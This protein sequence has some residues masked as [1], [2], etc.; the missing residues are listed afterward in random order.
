LLG[1]EETYRPGDVLGLAEAAERRVGEHQLSHLLG[2]DLCQPGVDVTRRDH[3]RA[4]AAVAELARKGLREPDD[5]RLRGRV[6]R[7]PA[8]PR[9]P[10]VT[11]AVFPSSDA[12][13]KGS[14]VRPFTRASA[15]RA[16]S[17]PGK[18]AGRARSR[19]LRARLRTQPGAALQPP[20]AARV[21]GRAAN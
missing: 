19:R 2:N 12:K 6:V 14:A 11:R 17:K 15:G 7:L 3:V 4:N 8:I 18:D 10:P 16:K 1:T 13:G 9:D 5:P 21:G 20:G